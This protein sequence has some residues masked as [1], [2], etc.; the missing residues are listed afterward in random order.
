MNITLHK[1]KGPFLWLSGLFIACLCL[2]FVTGLYVIM[3]VPFS[4]LL[5][6]AGWKQPGFIFFALLFTIPFSF[7]YNLT[8]VLGTDIPDEGLMLLSAF[9]CFGI[10]LYRP[11]LLKLPA[12]RHPLLLFLLLHFGWFVITA[13]T[14]ENPILSVK[15][16][17]AKGWYIGAFVLSAILVFQ[18]R[19]SI[20]IAAAALVISMSV[21]V[22][23]AI[24][25]HAVTG[26]SFATINDAVYPF[27]RNHVNYSSLLVCIIP[28]LIAF[29]SLPDNLKVKRMA[30]VI[31]SICLVALFFS[32]ARGAWVAL[33]AGIIA[34]MLIRKK[35]IVAVYVSMILLLTATFLWLTTNDKYVRFAHDFNTTIF[36]QDF[37]EHLVATYQLK[38][39]ST[40]ERFHRWI[41]GIRMAADKP[42]TGFGPGTFYHHYKPYTV[43]AFQTWVSDN[44]EHSTV[45]NYFILLLAEQGIPGLIL[46]LLLVGA[47]L[48]YVQQNYHL[49]TG[50]FDRT[51]SLVIGSII[52][53]ILTVNLLSD[54]IETDK[55]GSVF[56]LCFSIV[57]IT[58]AK[59]RASKFSPDVQSI[60]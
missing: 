47:L 4:A 24:I 55:I 45:H 42:M 1:V 38:D 50:K 12:W 51:M 26:F 40:A 31:L 29:Y 13:I 58:H 21:I 48:Y 49:A 7:E 34:V 41:A 20:I 23:I 54:L 37:K 44:K 27:F 10:L 36:H 56:F 15:I 60:S 19:S 25:R 17:L 11:G 43:P 18:K 46:F 22:G 6:Y 8:P 33:V 39:L 52:A 9:L 35:L 5:F 59:I 16:I 28:V 30:F 3:A 53:M 57:V 2:S 14:S 32:Y